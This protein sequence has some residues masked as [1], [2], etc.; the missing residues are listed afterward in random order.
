MR[1]PPN[2]D[3]ILIKNLSPD[4]GLKEKE[5]IETISLYGCDDWDPLDNNDFAKRV[6]H[7][8]IFSPPQSKTPNNACR[9]EFGRYTENDPLI[10]KIQKIAFKFKSDPES[11]Q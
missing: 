4:F 1:F 10:I 6:Q 9:K 11:P 7:Y 3:D 5:A 2:R 8:S